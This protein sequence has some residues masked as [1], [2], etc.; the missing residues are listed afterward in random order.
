[1]GQ[2]K[3]RLWRIISGGRLA[4][5]QRAAVQWF[6]GTTINISAG[7]HGMSE[8]WTTS[9]FSLHTARRDRHQPSI[10]T[11]PEHLGYATVTIASHELPQDGADI[12]IARARLEALGRVLSAEDTTLDDHVIESF[13]IAD[14]PTN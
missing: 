7:V 5:M 2:P 3:T 14:R 9:T 8:R 10:G 11:T 1:M 12:H 13:A 4:S 6:V